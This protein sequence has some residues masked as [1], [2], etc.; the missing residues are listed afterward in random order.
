MCRTYRVI[1][2][3]WRDILPLLKNESFINLVIFQSLKQSLT[4]LLCPLWVCHSHQL[5]ASQSRPGQTR[6]VA[7]T[8]HWAACCLNIT[9]ILIQPIQSATPAA[10]TSRPPQPFLLCTCSRATSTVTAQPSASH[11]L[12]SH[13]LPPLWG[14]RALG[15]KL[16]ATIRQREHTSSHLASLWVSHLTHSWCFHLSLWLT[17]RSQSRWLWQRSEGSTSKSQGAWGGQAPLEVNLAL[18]LTTH[19]HPPWR[20]CSPLAPVNVSF[21]L[22]EIHIGR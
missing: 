8:K 10:S 2:E 16:L 9:P 1:K 19:P 7:N 6:L 11:P 20:S 12:S 22:L 18:P 13:T 14:F 4:S 5:T 15:R 17:S 21:F 3:L